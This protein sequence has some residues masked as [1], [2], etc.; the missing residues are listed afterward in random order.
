MLTQFASATAGLAVRVEPG[1]SYCYVRE[2]DEDHHP[3]V[4]E[5]YVVALA[6][7]ESKTRYG[8]DWSKARWRETL[9]ETGQ[10]G[11]FD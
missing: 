1:I 3:I 11:L 10:G 8:F 4:E 7:V 9:G 2:R 5:L 6:T